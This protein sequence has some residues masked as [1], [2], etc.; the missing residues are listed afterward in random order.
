MRIGVGEASAQQHLV[1]R[2]AGARHLVAGRERG[3]LDL[4]VVV[5]E[6]AVQHQLADL[7]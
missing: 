7:L 2:Q 5:G 3:L 1:R 6:V 4:G